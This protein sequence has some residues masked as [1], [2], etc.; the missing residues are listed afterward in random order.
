M[1]ITDLS[2]VDSSFL[3]FYFKYSSSCLLAVGG[4]CCAIVQ[5]RLRILA[6][7]SSNS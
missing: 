3:E 5:K 7:S 6:V 4:Y 2:A 1:I